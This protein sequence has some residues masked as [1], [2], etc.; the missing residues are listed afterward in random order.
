[1]LT[2]LGD[3]DGTIDPS[4]TLT[5][6]RAE[7][8]EIRRGLDEIEQLAQQ[9]QS[10]AEVIPIEDLEVDYPAVAA[11]AATELAQGTILDADRALLAASLLPRELGWRALAEGLQT[12]DAHTAWQETSL[13][14]VLSAFRGSSPELVRRIATSTGLHADVFI[15]GLE[16]N[17]IA[18][19]ATQLH[20]QTEK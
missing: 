15:A 13:Q 10:F 8:E 9:A 17:Q 1:M 18:R 14:D 7:I 6:E 19:L 3:L 16:P 5:L 20:Q 11:A 12:T 2:F 4:F